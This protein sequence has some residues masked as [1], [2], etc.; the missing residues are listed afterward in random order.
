MFWRT[1]YRSTFRAAH[2]ALCLARAALL[3]DAAVV[4]QPHEPAGSRACHPHRTALRARRA[5]IRGGAVPAR[6]QHCITPLARMAPERRE[7]ARRP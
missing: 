6:P 1:A 7:P 2:R 3:L 4:E 5:R